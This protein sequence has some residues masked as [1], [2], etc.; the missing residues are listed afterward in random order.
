MKLEGQISIRIE[1][2]YTSI[3][4]RDDNACVTFLEVRLTPEQLSSALSR[5]ANTDCSIELQGLEKIGKKHENKTFE[6]PVKY[7]DEQSD[8]ELACNESLFEQGLYEWKSD[9]YYRSQNSFFKKGNEKWA[10]VTIRRWI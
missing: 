5:I 10:R 9:Q 4:V 1:R 8:L 2:E 6:F 7:S 3:E